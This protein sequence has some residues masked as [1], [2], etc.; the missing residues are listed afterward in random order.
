[1]S[2]GWTMLLF[3]G[4]FALSV[5]SSVVLAR[6]LEQLGAWLRLSQ[7]LLG[8]VAALGA[9]APEISSAVTAM[10][11]GQHDLGLGIVLGSNIFNLAALLGLSALVSGKVSVTRQTLLINGSVAVWVTLGIRRWRWAGGGRSRSG[12][13]ARGSAAATING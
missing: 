7:S 8:I 3:L 1:M 10:H 13:S 4:S 6:R 2:I 9:D 5:I 11:A 12:C